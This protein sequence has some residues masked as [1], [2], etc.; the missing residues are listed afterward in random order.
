MDLAAEFGRLEEHFNKSIESFN[1]RLQLAVSAPEKP[2]SLEALLNDLTAFKN[3]ISSSLLHIKNLFINID[4][5]MDAIENETRKSSILIH[6]IVEGDSEDPV[7]LVEDVVEKLN[8]SDSFSSEECIEKVY[9]LGK[10][11]DK[12][13]GNPRPLLVTFTKQKYK[14]KF[15]YS[16]K[17]LKGTKILITE[18]LTRGRQELYRRCRIA[19]GPGK[20]WTQD[21]SINVLVGNKRM[22]ISSSSQIPALEQSTAVEDDLGSQASQKQRSTRTRS[23]NVSR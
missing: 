11:K 14:N 7:V 8:L 4:S 19:F 12:A 16:K 3:N 15:W 13:S 6:G 18:F 2:T 9:R 17:K 21:G 1:R 20:V 23:K 5:R 22:V 10:K